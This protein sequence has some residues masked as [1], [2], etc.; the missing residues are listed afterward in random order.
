MWS[1]VTMLMHLVL[2]RPKEMGSA[3]C[4]EDRCISKLIKRC[5]MFKII[6]VQVPFNL[7]IP[8]PGVISKEIT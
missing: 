2:V 1:V 6:K 5:N 7:E 8:L 3:I 4:L